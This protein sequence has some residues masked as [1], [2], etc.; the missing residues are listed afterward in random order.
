MTKTSGGGGVNARSTYTFGKAL[1]DEEKTAIN[2]LPFTPLAVNMWRNPYGFLP[3]RYKNGSTL[4]TVEETPDGERYFYTHN[5]NGSERIGKYVFLM[6]S[7]GDQF[8]TDD[9]IVY[10]PYNGGTQPTENCSIIQT[11]TAV[12]NPAGWP[13]I[14]LSNLTE[15]N[16]PVVALRDGDPPFALRWCAF[17]TRHDWNTIITLV[18]AHQLAQPFINPTTTI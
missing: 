12:D 11:C 4:Q 16:N 2:R 8:S 3:I 13:W 5:P 14:A 1:T 7:L 15:G 9:V 10:S 18:N 6:G 17:Y